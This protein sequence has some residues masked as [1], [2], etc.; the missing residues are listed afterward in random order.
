MSRTEVILD[1]MYQYVNDLSPGIT[2]DQ[3]KDTM[4]TEILENSIDLVDLMFELE[5]SLNLDQEELDMKVLVP[6]IKELNFMNLAEEINQ[7]L[8][9]H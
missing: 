2:K 9:N 8:N 6:K 3:M 1:I 4:V 7:Y 5:D